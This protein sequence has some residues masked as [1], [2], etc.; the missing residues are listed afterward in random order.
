MSET[1]KEALTVGVH[2][3]NLVEEI[4]LPNSE[5]EREMS[6][7]MENAYEVAKALLADEDPMVRLRAAEVVTKLLRG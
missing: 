4:Y 6:E 7:A 3:G 1:R 5:W 2:N